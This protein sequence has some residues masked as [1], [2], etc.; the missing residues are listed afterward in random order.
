MC[1]VSNLFQYHIT[2]EA[3]LQQHIRLRACKAT[4]SS[5]KEQKPTSPQSLV[6]SE[7][8]RIPV[9][10]WMDH[11]WGRSVSLVSMRLG[12]ASKTWSRGVLVQYAVLKPMLIHQKHNV[13]WSI[14]VLTFYMTLLICEIKRYCTISIDSAIMRHKASGFGRIPSPVLCHRWSGR[15]HLVDLP[16]VKK[17]DHIFAR[18]WG[19]S[20]RLA[21]AT[22]PNF[23]RRHRSSAIWPYAK[24]RPRRHRSHP[25]PNQSK[26]YSMWSLPEANTHVPDLHEKTMARHRL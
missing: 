11:F 18:V 8:S 12:I 22:W 3:N 16:A 5:R 26:W 25:R 23:F 13:Y 9:V 6:P 20:G 1:Y 21:K 24:F 7:S 15:V 19:S 4:T 2:G 10:S 17:L 14:W